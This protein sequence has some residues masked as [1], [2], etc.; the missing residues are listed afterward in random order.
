MSEFLHFPVQGG[1]DPS[2]LFIILMLKNQIF[3]LQYYLPHVLVEI[4][5]KEI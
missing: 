4:K 1:W 3:L 5:K 2:C